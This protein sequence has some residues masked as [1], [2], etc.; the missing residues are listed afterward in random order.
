MRRGVTS[1]K[2]LQNEFRK[3]RP[4]GSGTP[5]DFGECLGAGHRKFAV[6]CGWMA[7]SYRTTERYG[8]S[9][10]SKMFHVE[11][12]PQNSKSP[13]R[14]AFHRRAARGAVWASAFSALRNFINSVKT[15][16]LSNDP[17]FQKVVEHLI[18]RLVL[19]LLFQFLVIG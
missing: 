6:P 13:D 10:V 18:K 1:Q 4:N 12:L 8:T 5:D 14:I 19:L 3:A 15:S 17:L 2:R 16:I 9:T 7:T 11:H